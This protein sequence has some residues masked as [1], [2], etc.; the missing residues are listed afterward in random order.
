MS[1]LGDPG[2]PDDSRGEQ[3]WIRRRQA[4]ISFR[5]GETSVKL[6][7]RELSILT[8]LN[9]KAAVESAG[10]SLKDLVRLDTFV[11]TS[12]MSEYRTAGSKAKG[13]VLG[14]V[15]VPG[16][17]VFVSGLM[18]PEAMIEIGAIAAID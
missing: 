6:K 2:N 9:V 16:A 11:V 15:R 14:D 18:I 13:E 12:V 4:E 17:T 8:T 10:G 1:R 3:K 5:L 7:P